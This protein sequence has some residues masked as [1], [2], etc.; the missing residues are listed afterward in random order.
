[1]L[2]RNQQIGI[3]FVAVM[4]AVG[5]VEMFAGDASLAEYQSFVA[6]VALPVV[7]TMIGASAV[8]KATRGDK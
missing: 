5:A 6:V 7:L 4:A 3:G 2:G 1:M 8:L